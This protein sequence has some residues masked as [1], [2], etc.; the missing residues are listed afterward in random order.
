MRSLRTFLVLAALLTASCA[1]SPAGPAPVH[2]G[3]HKMGSSQTPSN[4][5]S[6][7]NN[8][9]GNNA[10]IVVFD[11]T[12]VTG[13]KDADRVTV[14]C[15]FDQA[16]TILYQVKLPGSSTWRTVNGNGSGDAV[17]ASTFT[18]IDYL[19]LAYNSRIE[20]VTGGTGPS[21][22]EVQIGVVYDR[23]LAM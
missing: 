7:L 12:V 14:S 5:L 22:A 11:N 4:W 10:T 17:S 20:V 1:T 15:F 19:M 13:H 21:V 16:V 3:G 18:S 9:T 23:P 8:V 6:P 2:G